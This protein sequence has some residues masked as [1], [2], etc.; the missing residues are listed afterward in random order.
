MGNEGLIIGIVTS[1]VILISLLKYKAKL[2]L[3]V[4]VR[5]VLGGISIYLVNFILGQNGISTIIAINPLTILT[6]GL[7][8]FPGV[9]L[10]YAVHFLSLV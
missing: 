9:F 5:M 1:V 2:L 8:G 10:L 6:S 3:R 4:L 7:L